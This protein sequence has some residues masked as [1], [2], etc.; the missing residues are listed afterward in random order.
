MTPWGARTRAGSCQ[1]LQTRGARSPHWSRFAGRD[2]DPM[3]DSH[4][5]NLFLKDCTLRE[6]PTLGQFVKN[7]SPWEGPMFEKF[8]ENCLL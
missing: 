4:W 7:C 2:C 8:M 1:D 6:G 3:G 5:S